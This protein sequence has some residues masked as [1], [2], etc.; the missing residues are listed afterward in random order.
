M[1]RILTSISITIS[2]ILMKFYRCIEYCKLHSLV[3]ELS[4]LDICE[5]K[6]CFS[7]SS[8]MEYLNKSLRYKD[9]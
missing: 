5:K 8:F 4:T 7:Q 9:Y 2:N 6:I 3:F 1:K